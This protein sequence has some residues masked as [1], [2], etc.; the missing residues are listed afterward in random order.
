MIDLTDTGDLKAWLG[1]APTQ[2]QQDAMLDELVTA[3]SADFLRAIDRSDFSADVYTEVR[4]GDGGDAIALWHWPIAAIQTVNVAAAPITASADKVA[5]GWYIDTDLDPE[6]RFMLYLAGGDTFTDGASVVI[7][8]TAGYSAA[9]ADVAQA[10]LEWCAA[11]F[12]GRPGQGLNSQREAGGEH[13]T[14]DRDAAMP[15]NTA[16]VV[17]KYKRTWPS[18]NKYSDDRDYRVTRINKTTTTTIA[19]SK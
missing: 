6:R 12:K 1:I 15:A 8:Y 7:A 2:V 9:P 4:T 13:V 16:R 18:L 19:G 3:T 5:A 17:E 11:R 10:V 14:Y